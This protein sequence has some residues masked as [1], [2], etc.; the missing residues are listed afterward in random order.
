MKTP[1]PAIAVLLAATLSGCGSNPGAAP[2]E[3]RVNQDTC[4]ECGMIISDARH[5][6]AIMAARDGMEEQY[7]FDDTGEMFEFQLPPGA[8]GARRYVHDF[9]TGQWIDADTAHFVEAPDLRTP[10]GTGIVA[11]ATAEA[12]GAAAARHNGRIKRL[13]PMPALSVA[14]AD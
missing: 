2:P 5:A 7:L 1:L 8:T 10:M 13:P 3:I 11:Y 4:H 12:A 14:A 6:A 9:T